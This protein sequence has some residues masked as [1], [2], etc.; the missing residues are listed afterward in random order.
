MR[1]YTAISRENLYCHE[2]CCSNTASPLLYASSTVSHK[3]TL[4]QPRSV[5]CLASFAL[6]KSSRRLFGHNSA[7]SGERLHSS[8]AASRS[9]ASSSSPEPGAPTHRQKFFDFSPPSMIR[10]RHLPVPI[11]SAP[12]HFLDTHLAESLTLMRVEVLP[13]LHAELFDGLVD[14][15]SEALDARSD[16]LFEINGSLP[17][18]RDKCTDAI[19]ISRL[20]KFGIEMSITWIASSLVVHPSQPH[21]GE[22]LH[23]AGAPR[24]MSPYILKQPYASQDIALYV[25]YPQ[26]EDFR[27]FNGRNREMIERLRR[28]TRQLTSSMIFCTDALPVLEDMSRLHGKKF[29]WRLDCEYSGASRPRSRSPPPDALNVPCALPKVEGPRR[30]R[31]VRVHDASQPIPVSEDISIPARSRDDGVE[32]TPTC[33]DYIQKV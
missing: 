8:R 26:P 33:E 22:A 4:A 6:A 10:P 29:P 14:S 9:S 5:C 23:W 3:Q 11:P 17:Y 20:R 21:L 28:H 19:S 27:S 24:D 13:T 32:Y 2:H 18:R 7:M 16:S 12:F 25:C 30:S 31:R 15:F 1:Q